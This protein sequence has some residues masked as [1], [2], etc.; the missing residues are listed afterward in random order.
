MRTIVHLCSLAVLLVAVCFAVY[1]PSGKAQSDRSECFNSMDRETAAYIRERSIAIKGRDAE[2]Y[3]NKDGQVYLLHSNEAVDVGSGRAYKGTVA[4][5][6]HRAAGG[7]QSFYVVEQ[8]IARNRITYQLRRDG[9]LLETMPVTLSVPRRPVRATT[10]VPFDCQKY[11][12]AVNASNQATFQAKQAEANSTCQKV[13]VCVSMCYCK[14]GKVDE[15][16][17]LIEFKP[18]SRNCWTRLDLSHQFLWALASDRF[19]LSNEADVLTLNYAL[20]VAIR[21]AAARYTF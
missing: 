10:G 13:K 8:E 3:S 4:V 17:T 19:A 15:P 7:R 11:C 12:D 1:P 20:D 14:F 6:N 9:E 18:T 16:Q 21:R 5:L 2:F